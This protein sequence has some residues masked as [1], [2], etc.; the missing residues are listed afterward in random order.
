MSSLEWFSIL[1]GL[2]LLLGILRLWQETIDRK[3]EAAAVESLQD[4]R[5]RGSARAVAQH[6][7]IHQSLCIGC[8]SCIAACPEEGVLGLVAGVAHV[9]HASRCVGH[10]LC[11]K[12]CP[13]GAVKVGLGDVSTRS[14]IPRLELTGETSVPGLYIAGELGGLALIRNA[15]EQG[16]KVVD[17]IAQRARAERPGA[18]VAPRGDCAFDLLIVGAGPAGLSAS[19]KAKERGLRCVTIDQDEIGGT[20]RKYPRRKMTLV[21]AVEI[22]LHGKIKGCEI[23]KEELIA[24]W[25]SIIEKHALEIRR[26]VRLQSLRRGSRGFVAETSRGEI[27]SRY[28][29]LALGRRGTPRKLGVP[30]EDSEKVFYQLID[31]ADYTGQ[32]LLVVGGGDSAVEAAMALA[33]QRGNTVHISYR[34]GGF[35]RLKARNE[36]RIQE[37]LRS[38]RVKALFDSRVT[39]IEPELV[40]LAVSPGEG[41]ARA[42]G[43]GAGP[44][45]REQAMSL[46][47]DHVFIFAGG[48]PPFELLRGAGVRFW[49]EPELVAER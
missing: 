44:A 10:A 16:A 2:G 37:Y 17:T 40:R 8:G 3:E 26:P 23:A 48:D 20:I 21:Q 18:F 35:F 31:A 13:V 28:V 39:A 47:N 19:L 6:P 46:P 4:A 32:R 24:L 25:T 22:P 41:D 12:A 45:Q 38:G 36:E 29:L 1:G 43:T 14:D 34:K 7:T 42:G 11:E 27:A 49:A 5:A 15:V 9:I 30:G 33:N